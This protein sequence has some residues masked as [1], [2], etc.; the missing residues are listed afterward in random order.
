MSG[1]VYEEE[2]V[3]IIKYMYN[4]EDSLALT[5]MVNDLIQSTPAPPKTPRRR[6]LDAAPEVPPV[7]GRV[8]FKAFL[9]VL[10]DFQL[11]GHQRFLARFHSMF[12]EVDTDANGVVDEGTALP[13]PALCLQCGGLLRCGGHVWAHSC[14]VLVL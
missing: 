10:L 2:W 1:H 14:N 8:K 5:V 13:V 11:K 3:D 4:H 7:K 9:K 12:C 6:R